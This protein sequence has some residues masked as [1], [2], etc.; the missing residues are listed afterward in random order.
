MSAMSSSDPSTSAS[1]FATP[2]RIRLAAATRHLVDAVLTSEDAS[3]EKLD[4]AAD[5]TEHAIA[6]LLGRAVDTTTRPGGERSRHERRQE[7]YLPRS[8]LVGSISPVAPPL[9]YEFHRDHVVAH[10]SFGAAYEGPPGYVHGGWVALAFDEALGMANAVSGHP[11]MTA[12]LTVRYRRPTPLRTRLHLHARTER[13]DGRRITT[14]ATL[15]SGDTVTAEAEGLFVIIGAERTLEY[16]GDRA[17]T[18]DP[19][20]PLP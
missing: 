3:D 15:R 17:M 19:T 8:P 20:D 16:F 1:A 9:A 14:V 7:D 12:R 5:A 6:D 18:P 2:A 13:V 4:A 11:G 10:G